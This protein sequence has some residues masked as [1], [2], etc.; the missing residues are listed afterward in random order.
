MKE[1]IHQLG[2]RVMGVLSGFDRVLF[3]GFVKGV[4]SERGLNG[5]LYGAKVAMTDFDI[6]AQ[7]VTKTVIGQSLA[8]AESL[9]MEVRYIDSSHVRKAD[10]AQSI[11]ERNN[12]TTGPICVLRAVE[13]CM[14]FAV[15]RDR[16]TKKI[17]LERRRRKCLH[18]Y[19]YFQHERFGLMH[20]RLQTWFPF[21]IQICLNGRQWL[22]RSLQAAGVPYLRRDNCISR[23]GDLALAQH[24][25]DQ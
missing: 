6:H 12:I 4:I 24:L 22:A 7:Q 13:P 16:A 2:K 9:G 15:R 20:V 10:V 23:V 17:W 19:H 8:E 21:T 5:Y 3:R 1:L 11:A 25:L 18:L 14:S